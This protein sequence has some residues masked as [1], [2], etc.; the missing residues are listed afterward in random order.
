MADPGALA[1]PT[2][3]DLAH[4]PPKRNMRPG[5]I[6][7]AECLQRGRG[8]SVGLAAVGADR[9]S[10]DSASVPLPTVAM[11]RSAVGV[12]GRVGSKPPKTYD[13]LEPVTTIEWPLRP[14]GGESLPAACSAAGGAA[15]RHSMGLVGV[16]RL[17]HSNAFRFR[18]P[19]ANHSK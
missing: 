2:T 9:V 16:A 7:S 17:C 10:H 6:M 4:L 8:H 11:Q 5:E 12:G 1:A 19:L 15:A 14:L 18:P 3:N 13:L